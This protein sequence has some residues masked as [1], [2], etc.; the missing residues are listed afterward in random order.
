MVEQ[1]FQGAGS[2][3]AHENS[4]QS[5]TPRPSDS[6]SL[7]KAADFAQDA[8]QKARTAAGNVASSV[9]GNVKEL[10]DQQLATGVTMATQLAASVRV[11]A[12]DLEQ[13]APM[14]GGLVRGFANT[15]DTYAEAMQDQTVDQ[16][17]QSASRFTRRQ[18][19]LVFGLTALAG[20]LAYRTF[21]STH[22]IA[23][24]AIQPT[25]NP[26]SMGRDHG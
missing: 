16:L 8:A 10:L 12:T 17:V 2:T 5:G 24:P 6:P 7:S 4:R 18:P 14:L 21:K 20:F 13:E 25:Q 19:A 11:A 9:T 15:V 1:H 26:D 3:A 22:T 23:A